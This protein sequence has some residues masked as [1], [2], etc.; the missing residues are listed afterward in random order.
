MKD[1]TSFLRGWLYPFKA[2]CGVM[3][4]LFLSSVPTHAQKVFSSAV[5]YSSA[6]IDVNG[7]LWVWGY[8]QYNHLIGTSTGAP[9]TGT[10]PKDSTPVMVAFPAGVTSWTTVALGQTHTVALGSD[11]NLYAWGFNNHGQLG[12]GTTTQDSVPVMVTKPGGVTSWT[13]V[14][15][16]AFH[17]I[18]IGNDGNVYVWGF[19]SQ[20]QL[21][22]SA[23]TDKS[24]PTMVSLP[25]AVTATE[26][27]AS[28]NACL[29]LAS[30]GKIYAWGKN[31]NGQLGDSTT[32]DHIT[33]TAVHLWGVTPVS[34]TSGAFFNT[35]LDNNGNIWAWGQANNGQTGNGSTSPSNEIVP[36]EASKPGGVTSWNSYAVGASFVLAIGNDGN[37]YGWG[38]GG[39]GEMGNGT[40]TS[41]NTT[42]VS[43]S[44]PSGIVA[45]KVAAGHNHGFIVDT[46]DS[47]YSWGRN[48][49]GQL[50]INIIFNN[51]TIRTPEAVVG[52]GGSGN[53]TLPVEVAS[54]SA[55]AQENSVVLEWQTKTEVQ[56]AGFNVLR[57]D[58]GSSSFNVIST[59]TSNKSLMGLVSS[60]SGKNYSYT[61]ATVRTGGMYYYEIQSVAINGE[62]KSYSPVA[63]AVGGPDNFTVGQNYPNPFNPS[64]TI[65]YDIPA[66]GNVMVRVYSESGQEVKTLVNAFQAPGNYKAVWN[67]D[68]NN[69]MK[70]SSGI[71]F[72]TVTMQNRQE[73]VKKMIL[74]K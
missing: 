70:V 20:G 34:I 24:T 51:D 56:N 68:D 11:G 21:A 29:A 54:F 35:C 42:I 26:V 6:A 55:T 33:P 40:L 47:L 3:L 7:N 44:L 15:C 17:N 45:S 48:F 49:E 31:A 73:L 5:A 39:T 13:A 72:Y 69:G 60:A 28:S 63:V 37:T 66:P 16:G 27:S 23:L 18:A 38:F 19:N 25:G 67:G 14:A 41:N 2:A 4:F 43:P 22:D 61:D 32:H 62:T 64:T 53:L 74:M 10:V 58:P 1:D 59:Y 46:G 12:N 36:V 30:D 65:N 50:G 9:P 57:K 52:T 71:Y 8:D